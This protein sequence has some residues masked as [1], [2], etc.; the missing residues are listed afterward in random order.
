MFSLSYCRLIVA[1][2]LLVM[3]LGQ[4][5]PADAT[6][7]DPSDFVSCGSFP[8]ATGTYSFNTTGP[9]PTLTIPSGST[10]SG[11]SVNGI[12]VFTF[13]CIDISTGMTLV[14]SGSQPLALLSKSSA[15]IDGNGV[16]NVSG[17]AAYRDNPGAGGP[18]GGTGGGGRIVVMTTP[19][20]FFDSGSVVLSGGVNG[21]GNGV[22]T[23]SETLV[24]EPSSIV[25]LAIGTITAL[26]FTWR[27]RRTS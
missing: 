13:D 1:A 27:R 25:L 9:T 18:G 6:L 7:L 10:I 20:G 12:A 26:A 15:I 11:I 17:Q 21:G 23:I 14:G 8:T 5:T 16:I 4:T 22:F 19:D 3:S 24:P 2:S